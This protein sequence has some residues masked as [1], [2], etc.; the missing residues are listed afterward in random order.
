MEIRVRIFV[1]CHS[2]NS[3]FNKQNETE[4]VCIHSILKPFSGKDSNVSFHCA[5]SSRNMA[6]VW[7]TNVTNFP[8]M[9]TGCLL[10]LYHQPNCQQEISKT[11]SEVWTGSILLETCLQKRRTRQLGFVVSWFHLSMR[12]HNKLLLFPDSDENNF[13]RTLFKT[14]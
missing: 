4:G 5:F 8:H 7:K 11:A 12:L 13:H 14:H 9:Q 1:K 2:T 6:R 10:L 3:V